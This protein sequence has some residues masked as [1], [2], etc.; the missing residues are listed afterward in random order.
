[1]TPVP[2]SCC[3]T[4]TSSQPFVT[5]HVTMFQSKISFLFNA[6]TP[7]WVAKVVGAVKPTREKYV[8]NTEYIYIYFFNS[9]GELT[10]DLQQVP[11]KNW[12]HLTT[13][14]LTGGFQSSGWSP[15]ELS[16]TWWAVWK[17]FLGDGLNLGSKYTPV[18]P[19][20]NFWTGNQEYPC[21][22]LGGRDKSLLWE[23][24]VQGFVRNWVAGEAVA[25]ASS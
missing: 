7:V 17:W 9:L 8:H 16:L 2:A 14:L 20:V 1:M 3:G 23:A 15:S 12:P 19:W 24:H 6:S 21:T 5:S 22:V 18:L 13:H 11:P 10:E 4:A 25:S